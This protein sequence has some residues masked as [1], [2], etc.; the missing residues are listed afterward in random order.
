M[1]KPYEYLTPRVMSA[2]VFVRC[3]LGNGYQPVNPDDPWSEKHWVFGTEMIQVWI[4]GSFPRDEAGN[5]M[6]QVAAQSIDGS[7]TTTVVATMRRLTFDRLMPLSILFSDPSLEVLFL[8]EEECEWWE[9]KLVLGGSGEVDD[10]PVRLKDLS[11]R[12][13]RGELPIDETIEVLGQ[14]VEEV[15]ADLAVSYIEVIKILRRQKID[16]DADIQI[17]TLCRTLGAAIDR[18]GFCT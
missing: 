15:P 1:R 11:A 18:G 16:F 3:Y 17:A 13:S 8:R 2:E 5:E 7:E 4:I 10:L 6:V 14:V 12:W 9:P